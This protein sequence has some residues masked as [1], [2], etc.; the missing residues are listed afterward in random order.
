MCIFHEIGHSSACKYYKVPV[1]GVG[2]GV[3]AYRPVMFADVT[4]AWYLRL[5]QRLVVNVG[6]VYFQLIYTSV[7]FLLGYIDTE[8]MSI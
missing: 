2:F 6:G 1:N 7:F 5:N 4:G 8:S 3:A